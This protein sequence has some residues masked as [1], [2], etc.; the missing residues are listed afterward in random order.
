MLVL[1]AAG[2]YHQDGSIVGVVYLRV[3]VSQVIVW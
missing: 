2:P 1:T 3:L